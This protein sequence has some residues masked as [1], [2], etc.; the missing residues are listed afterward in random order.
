MT[1]ESDIILDVKNLKRYYPIKSGLFGRQ[2]GVAKVLDGITFQVKR[3]ETLGIAGES[4]SGKTV[5]LRTLLRLI[6]PTAGSVS[7]EGRD[8][9]TIKGEEMRIVRR[10]MQ[11][12]FQDPVGSL[13]PRMTIA[14][15]LSEPFIIHKV[16]NKDEREERVKQL[17]S[18]VG[19]NPEW[20]SRYPHQF[21]GG[22]RQ[23]IGVARA[24]ALNPKL[25]LAD[26]PVSALDV[27]LQAQVLNLF[28][29]LQDEFKLTY[30]FVAHDL[31]VL[32]QI[33]DRI[34]IILHGRLVEIANADAIYENPIHPYT[35][36][37]LA[38]SPSIEAGLREADAA[39]L[40]AGKASQEMFRRVTSQAT[41]DSA[42]L[43]EVEPGHWVS[44]F[45]ADSPN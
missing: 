27:S 10:Q 31:A 38:S 22:Q 42:D 2:T 41:S 25:I 35:Q 15:T 19:L 33:C 36:V 30:V 44:A 24:L 6:E 18:L 14:Q 12:I 45:S 29:D 23:R 4:G 34:A 9:Q 20:R 1:A 5:L 37:L 28:L 39:S 16:G 17:L 32:R 40:A 13:H 21:S 11:I 43:I 8:L 3:R 7:F 26:E